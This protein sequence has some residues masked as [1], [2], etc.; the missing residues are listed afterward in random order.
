MTVFFI[1]WRN[2]STA[3]A[4]DGLIIS[5]RGRGQNEKENTIAA[6]DAALHSGAQAVECDLRLT[7]DNRVIVH[8]G[9]A[10][11]SNG[12]HM[13]IKHHTIAE[14]TTLAR[15]A[16]LSLLTLEELF[17]YISQVRVPF[18]LEIKNP[19]PH[20]VASV[21]ELIDRGNLWG[22]VSLLGFPG[23][24][25]Q[26]ILAQKTESKLQVWRLMLFPFASQFSFTLSGSG[27][28]LGWLDS[29]PGSERLF[30]T[31]LNPERLER[32]RRRFERSGMSVVAGVINRREGFDLFRQAG[33]K[34]I[35]T[36]NI[37]GAIACSGSVSSR[38]SGG[39]RNP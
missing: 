13:G 38:H 2:G 14:V 10:L 17:D 3:L 4:A 29:I 8:H 18:F 31:M 28:F 22:L 35:V 34:D 30:R 9:G 33:I 24:V 27:V 7:G 32:L 37:A 25:R 5:H 19:S 16:D 15:D 20:L 11:N 21:I 36:D 1:I 23:L 26:A 12:K 39:G 6:F